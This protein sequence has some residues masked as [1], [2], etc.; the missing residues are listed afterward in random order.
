MMRE[1][2]YQ[3][4]YGDPI[5]NCEIKAGEMDDA[6]RLNN[7]GIEA[8]DIATSAPNESFLWSRGNVDRQADRETLETNLDRP[9]SITH[10]QKTPVTLIADRSS[11]FR[12]RNRS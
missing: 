2:F 8:I 9:W 10:R 6:E 7:Q 4:Q 1:E 12:E 11:R 5:N 3:S